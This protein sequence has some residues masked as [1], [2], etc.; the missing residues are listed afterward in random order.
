MIGYLRR[1][2]RQ[3]MVDSVCPLCGEA[4]PAALLKLHMQLEKSMR[5]EMREA[6]PEWFKDKDQGARVSEEYRRKHQRIREEAREL[7][8]RA[9]T[10]DQGFSR[11]DEDND[12]DSEDDNF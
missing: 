6:N 12:L 1:E 11:E 8:T 4:V 2:A 10:Y 9:G 5:R 7:R 3:T